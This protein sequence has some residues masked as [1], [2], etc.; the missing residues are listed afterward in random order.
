[1]TKIWAIFD[2]EPHMPP[3]AQS[4]TSQRKVWVS[5]SGRTWTVDYDGDEPTDEQIRRFVEPTP[6]EMDAVVKSSADAF[7]VSSD[8]QAKATRAMGRVTAKAITKIITSYNELLDILVQER[9]PTQAEVDQLKLTARSWKV[10]LAAGRQ[11]N[12]SEVDANT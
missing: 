2:G 7:M 8:P 9:F 10:L 5:P 3:T 11:E 4:P 1:M 6:A 12:A